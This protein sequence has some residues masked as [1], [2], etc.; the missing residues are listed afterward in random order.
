MYAYSISTITST[1]IISILVLVYVVHSLSFVAVVFMSLCVFPVLQWLVLMLWFVFYVVSR[2]P[3]QS[4]S[5]SQFAPRD[6]YCFMI[7]VLQFASLR[8]SLPQFCSLQL[9]CFIVLFYEIFMVWVC[10][11][12]LFSFIDYLSIGCLALRGRIPQAPQ[13]IDRPR[14]RI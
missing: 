4:T 14:I 12:L 6:M 11:V 8:G 1:S 7:S 5:V 10:L 3:W 2:T 9:C 13:P